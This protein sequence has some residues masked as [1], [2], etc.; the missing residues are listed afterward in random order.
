MG[1][2]SDVPASA[3]SKSMSM[4]PELLDHVSLI[5][6]FPQRAADSEGEL[7]ATSHASEYSLGSSQPGVGLIGK[8]GRHALFLL[9]QDKGEEYF[10]SSV[11][12]HGGWAVSWNSYR[13]GLAIRGTRKNSD[14]L[15][16]RDRIHDDNNS[17]R[18]NSTRE[19]ALEGAIGLG[20][21]SHRLKCDIAVELLDQEK[22]YYFFN[23]DY[24]DTLETNLRDSGDPS[25]SFK[26]RIEFQSSGG[27]RF[28][29]VGGW[30]KPNR[31]IDGVATIDTLVFDL[32]DTLEPEQ[33]FGG[34]ALAFPTSHVDLLRL[35][36]FIRVTESH[37]ELTSSSSFTTK[38]SRTEQVWLGAAVQH[39]VIEDLVL[40]AGME[41]RYQR[42]EVLQQRVDDYSDN[43]EADQ[44]E[45]LG[46]GFAWGA[47]YRWRDIELTGS[48]RTTLSTNDLF[49]DLDARLF[50]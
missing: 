10:G 6:M 5:F 24:R 47:T 40:S 39:E 48:A 14:D 8:A 28:V 1:N 30:A 17:L 23:R 20:Y 33:W 15:S 43:L 19:K 35:F 9:A 49:L 18:S 13:L 38:K 45:S 22:S 32:R 46:K 37:D 44:N 3:Y 2:A 36:S 42:V 21:Q 26:G 50:F 29:A 12:F 11:F 34:M 27:N 25:L 41:G 31:E 16:S 4:R 7:F